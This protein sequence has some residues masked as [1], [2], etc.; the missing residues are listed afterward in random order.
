MTISEPTF[1]QAVDFHRAGRLAEAQECY[2]RVLA[3]QGNHAEATSLLGVTLF[4]Q[5]RGSEAV[6]FCVRAVEMQPNSADIR[7][8]A[9]HVL[10]ADRQYSEALENYRV[11]IELGTSSPEV[12]N[13]FA[14]CLKETGQ[15]DEATDAYEGLLEQHPEN[16][17]GWNN[18]AAVHLAA[19]RVSDAES[20]VRQALALRPDFAKAR[21]NLQRVLAT[22]VPFWHFSMLNDESRNAAFEAAINRAVGEDSLVL[23]IGT[24]SGLLAMMA[25]R[26]GAGKV[27]ACEMVPGVADVARQIIRANELDDRIEV[28]EGKS[29]GLTLGSELPRKPDVL[30]AEVFDSGLLGEE[31]LDTVD[32]A[33]RRLLSSHSTLIPSAA[34]LVGAL[35]ESE[36]LLR[37]GSAGVVRGF[38]LTGFNAFR[39]DSFQHSLA[40]IEY[41]PLSD[42]F[43]IFHIDFLEEV[44]LA[45]QQQLDVPVMSGGTCHAIV[46]WFDLFL[47]DR[48][49]F[50]T[51]P[52]S[53]ETHWNQ[54]VCLVPSAPE[55]EAGQVISVKAEHNRRRLTLSM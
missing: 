24:G 48:T 50:S 16:V 6:R 8:N 44:P 49:I 25:A 22:Q 54:K 21:K 13:N 1:R 23:D 11:A 33:R 15:L 26:A 20:C 42:A 7:V 45:D 32:D 9:G 53:A 19:G 34:R 43:E 5:G 27:I 46:Y 3:V 41:R 17:E 29:T 10:C 30:I 40:T 14:I 47:D 31:A 18:L 37:L 2:Q 51:S 38:D 4:Q 28:V 52:F 36:A 39:P 12:V 55:L 35:V